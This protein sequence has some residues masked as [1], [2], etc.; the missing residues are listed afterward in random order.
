MS[1]E[2]T[3]RIQRYVFSS[4]TLSSSPPREPLL[5][6]REKFKFYLALFSRYSKRQLRYSSSSHYRPAMLVSRKER[7][8]LGSDMASRECESHC[9][10]DGAFGANKHRMLRQRGSHRRRTATAGIL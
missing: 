10:S 5:G 2:K 6:Y 4:R 8:S 7:A 9:V 1:L 3:R